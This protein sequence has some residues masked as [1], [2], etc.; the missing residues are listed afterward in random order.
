MPRT[1]IDYSKN[2]IYKIVCNDLTIHDC[3]IGHTTDFTKRKRTHKCYALSEGKR[4]S[5]YKI[6]ETIRSNGGW[7]NWTM[8]EV[9]KYPCIDSNEAGARERYWYE[10]LGANLNT[11]VPNRSK[12][13]HSKYYTEKNRDKIKEYRKQYKEVNRDLIKE[14]DKIYRSTHIEQAIERKKKWRDLHR[15]EINQ[16]RREQRKAKKALTQQ[17]AKD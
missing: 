9:E 5:N 4:D 16:K 11:Q 6:Y 2:V 1:P 17:T 14:K 13:E 8:V 3:Y 10:Q 15:D 7:D 12:S